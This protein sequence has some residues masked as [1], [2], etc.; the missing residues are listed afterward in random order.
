MSKNTITT[1]NVAL[2]GKLMDF[3]VSKPEVS[4]KYYGYSYVVFSKDNSQL[5]EVNNDLVDDLKEEGKKVVKAEETNKKN[6]PWE[7]SIAL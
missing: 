4:K 3:L 6:N 5:N 2:S 1:T 7:F